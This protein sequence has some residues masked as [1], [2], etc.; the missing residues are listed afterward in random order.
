MS[1]RRNRLLVKEQPHQTKAFEFYD[2]LGESRSYEKVAT[3]FQV[4]TS[5]VKLWGKS[6][7]WRERIRDRDLDV[8]REVAN[9]TLDDAVSRS[10][11]N[12]QIVRMAVFQLA[13]AVAE[14]EVRMTLSDLDRLIRLEAFLSDEPESRRQIVIHDLKYKTDE[15]LQAIIDDEIA[16][17]EK[18]KLTVRAETGDQAIVLFFERNLLQPRLRS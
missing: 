14:G 6:F 15:E 10:E 1:G 11:R 9:R 12:M 4:A 18:I 7:E 2:S 8:A 16:S 5:T 3:E 13:K 17:I